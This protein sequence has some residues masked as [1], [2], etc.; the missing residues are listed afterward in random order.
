MQN[1]KPVSTPL[2]AHFK[3][4]TTLSP[5]IDDECDYMSRVPYSS[6]VGSLMYAMVCFRP[7]LSYIISVVSRYMENPIK[8]HWKE[9]KWIFRYL[10]GF[11]DIC[12]QFGRNRDGVIGYAD[13]NF[14]GDRDKRSSLTGYVFTV[15]SCAISWKVTL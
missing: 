1:V 9:V 7:N 4:S 5:K 10:Y 3:L 8:E 14:V 2:E 15:G 11:V 12:L 13:S 6:A